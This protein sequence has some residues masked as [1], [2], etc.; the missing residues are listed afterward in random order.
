[1]VGKTRRLDGFALVAGLLA[2]SGTALAQVPESA[3]LPTAEEHTTT[4]LPE[5]S[6]HWAYIVDPIFPHLVA[7]KVWIVD[8]DA[9]DVVGMVNGGYLANATLAPD[10][11]RFYVTETYWSRGTRGERSDMV[12]TY[13][14][15]TLEP[16]G[17]VLLPEGRF[18]VVSKKYMAAVTPDGRYALSYNM[19]PATSVS[20][21]DV[22]NQAY[23]AD[24]EIPGCALVYPMGPTR[25]ASLCAD[26]SF[27]TV[28]FADPANPD[29]TRGDPWFDA[30]NDPVFEHP[31]FSQKEGKAYFVSYGGMVY[32]VDFT[33]EQPEVGEAWSLLAADEQGAW[34]PG[35]WQIASYHPG[36]QRL[37][38]QMHEGG[39]WSHKDAASEIWVFD[40]EAQERVQR[41]EL[42]QA[43][44]SSMV[45]QDDQPL[46]F[47]LDGGGTTSVYDA[48]TGEHRG[49]IGETGISP[50]LIVVTG[51]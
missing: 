34:W 44:W 35:G 51:E 29:I 43:A 27:I 8:G 24:I 49:D 33:G 48:T 38:V 32:P 36:S 2:L 9:L 25:F 1:M 17:E 7:T 18:L 40:V 15:R 37:F 42:A 4:T 14:A 19:A 22:E 20:V 3:Q 31:G 41:I 10:N 39:K 46:L 45:T 13:D 28:D 5:P 23:V 50:H 16:T 21:V 47:T 12:T 30:E 11:S 26:G 6:P